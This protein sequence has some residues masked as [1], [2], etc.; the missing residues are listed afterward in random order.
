MRKSLLFALLPLV[1]ILSCGPKDKNVPIVKKQFNA[2]VQKTFDDPSSL[3]E[4]VEINATDTISYE[5]IKA[6]IKLTDEGIEQYRELWSLRDSIWTEQMQAMLKGRKPKREPTYSER[7]KGATLLDD[8][9]SLTL[10][11]AKEKMN[12]TSLQQRI[13]EK[14][15][16]LAYHPAIYVYEVLF[17]KQESDGLKLKRVYAYMDSESGFKGIMPKKDDSQII[18]EDY[19]DVFK[20]SKECLVSSN[21]IQ[22]MYDEQ[23]EKWEELQELAQ[24]LM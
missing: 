9:S 15:S 24:R 20:L 6:L 19:N 10:K 4:I 13:K 21:S 17:R 5:S 11:I 8:C 14:D 2:Y 12:L 1:V 7:Y 23:K 3:K 22:G 16:N 18:S